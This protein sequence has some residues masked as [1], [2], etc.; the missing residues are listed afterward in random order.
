MYINS[1][2]DAQAQKF[3]LAPDDRTHLNDWGATVFARIIADLVVKEIP[4][5]EQYF[6]KNKTLSDALSAGL[7]PP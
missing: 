4:E 6:Q 7:P 5:L 3:N 2:G 1:I